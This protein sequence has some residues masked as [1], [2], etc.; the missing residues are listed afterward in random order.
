MISS[1]ENEKTRVLI[2]GPYPPPIGGVA[3]H[4]KNFMEQNS[5]LEKC[6]ISLYRTGKRDRSTNNIVQI[7]VDTSYILKYIVTRPCKDADAVHIHTASHWSFF[8]KIPY[9]LTSKFF[10]KS[11]V[12]LHVHGA[13]F[14]V[15][16]AESPKILKHLI[17]H[18]IKSSDAV[19]VTSPAWIPVLQR[20]GGDYNS[21]YPV[22]NGYVSTDF[23][24]VETMI[25]RTKLNIPHNKKVLIT[26]GALEVYKGHEYLIKSMR[27][28]ADKHDDIVVY[29][30]GEGSSK[31]HLR[32]L[33][34]QH[35]LEDTVILTGG[36][37]PIQELNLFMNA[38]DLFVL[39]SLHEGNPTVMF[40]ALGCG[41][42][43]VGTSVGGVPEVITSDECGLLVKPADPEDLAE[44]I[45][46]ALAREWDRE[47]I[48]AHAE[49]YTWVNIAKETMDIYKQV[50]G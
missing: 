45:L 15:F 34:K 13:E 46:Q 11:K 4:V 32:S 21:I 48:L 24:P 12:I 10:S 30:I 31:E 38:C 8:R 3:V 28:L 49:R 20:I 6:A 16:F 23:Y 39:P 27:L 19:I 33:I 1:S 42:P 18:V 9:V 41:K 36:D 5:V 35:S 26:V 43:F 2:I 50:L 29:I 40:E 17:R 44:K 37:K 7:I 25:A 14:D 22:P 47:A